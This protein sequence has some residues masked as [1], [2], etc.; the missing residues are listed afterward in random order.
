MGFNGLVKEGSEEE[1]KRGLVEEK[2]KVYKSCLGGL[3]GTSKEGFRGGAEEGFSGGKDKGS[4]EEQRR[5]SEE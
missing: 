5:N 4:E 2:I 3:R 1:Q